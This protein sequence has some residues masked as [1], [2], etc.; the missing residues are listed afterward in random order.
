M[1]VAATDVGVARRRFIDVDANTN[2]EI[3]AVTTDVKIA[4]HAGS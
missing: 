2:H 3:V 4:G 1:S